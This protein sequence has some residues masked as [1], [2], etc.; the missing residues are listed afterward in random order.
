M[1]G[2]IM[3]PEKA[4]NYPRLRLSLLAGLVLL[5]AVSCDS[6]HATSLDHAANLGQNVR[7]AVNP[8]AGNASPNIEADTAAR[9]VFLRPSHATR[10]PFPMVGRGGEP[11]GCRFLYAGL[12][13][14]AMCLPP[15]L[16]AGSGFYPIEEATMS[17]ITRALS[18]L[19]PAAVSP[20]AQFPNA[21]EAV[22]FAR[23]YLAQT[24]RAVSIV[25]ARRGFAVQIVGGL[26]V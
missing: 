21:S 25:P 14:P 1:P 9:A 4:R 24:G 2:A 8:A 7:V 13:N 5:L 10:A 26:T 19:F 3:L 20:V 18:R 17:S 23:Q 6:S 22:T 15:R 11:S 16:Q 12:A